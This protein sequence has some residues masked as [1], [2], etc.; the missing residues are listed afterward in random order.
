MVLRALSDLWWAP[1]SSVLP[2]TLQF[3][4][5]LELMAPG[6]VGGGVLFGASIFSS[7]KW[8]QSH[9][10]PGQGVSGI[11]HIRKDCSRVVSPGGY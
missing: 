10:K 1:G 11:K 2:G 7:V 9:N 3:L 5:K 8:G 4:E 6:M